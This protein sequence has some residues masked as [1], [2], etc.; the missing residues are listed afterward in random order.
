M[1]CIQEDDFIFEKLRWIAEL[2]NG[3]R[4]Y[5]DDGRPGLQEYSAWIRLKDYCKQEGIYITNL[6]LQFRSNHVHPLPAK[7]EGYFFSHK[8]A[9]FSWGGETYGFYLVGH[10]EGDVIKVKEYKVPELI[11]FR[12]EERSVDSGKGNIIWTNK[13]I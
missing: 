3:Q 13:S 2:S 1:V 10:V 9:I 6:Y 5:Q 12:E 4:V 7:A 8:S 11:L